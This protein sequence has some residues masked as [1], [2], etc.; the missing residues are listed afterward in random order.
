MGALGSIPGLRRSSGEGKGYPLQYS[1]LANSMDCIDHD[2]AKSR[3][4]LSDFHTHSSQGSEKLSH[5]PKVTQLVREVLPMTTET[6]STLEAVRRTA[7]VLF[8]QDHLPGRR[9]ARLML[10]PA[11]IPAVDLTA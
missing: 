1:G 2:V 3:T 5:M 8:V 7:D 10:R 4:R 11:C 6:N 9:E